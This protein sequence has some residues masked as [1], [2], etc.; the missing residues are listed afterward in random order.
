MEPSNPSAEVSTEALDIKEVIS[1]SSQQ[2]ETVTLSDSPHAQNM[3][4]NSTNAGNSMSVQTLETEQTS[5]TSTVSESNQSDVNSTSSIKFEK[6]D[7]A[8]GESST[9]HNNSKLAAV[10]KITTEAED[11][12]LSSESKENIDATKDKKLESNSES[13][14]NDES[15]ENF[16]RDESLDAVQH[17]PIDMTDSHIGLVEKEVRTDLDTLPEI[18]TE[19][20]NSDYTAAE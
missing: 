19:G 9:L 11:G 7:A 12:S 2:N 4:A 14:G 6:E 18:K 1:G 16:S 10:E 3:M 17:D 5:N 13:D 8:A 20:D 15:S